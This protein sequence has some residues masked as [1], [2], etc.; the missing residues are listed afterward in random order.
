MEGGRVK[1]DDVYYEL[2]E[3]FDMSFI[4]KYGTV[5][6]VFDDQNSGNICFGV[7][8]GTEKYFVKFAG[9]PTINGVCSQDEAIENLKVALPVYYDLAHENLIHLIKHEE[10]GKGYAAVFEWVDGECMGRMYPYSSRKFMQMSLGEKL[11]VFKDILKFH[12]YVHEK[13]YVAI[14]FY[15][16]SVLYDFNNKKTMICDIDFYSKKP[17][18]NNM[19]RLWGSSRFMSLEEFTLGAEIDEVTNVY[20]MGA[21][22]FALFS[23]Y[24][25]SKDQWPLSEELYDVVCRATSDER[26]LR[27]QSIKELMSEWEKF[28]ELFKKEPKCI[29]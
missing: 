3:P 15:D 18:I 28:V 19:E 4:N 16:G 10:I 2:K 25:R 8:N 11:Q 1:I 29:Y 6:K 22:A 14:D 27:Q 5:F 23:N 21:T 13:N 17:Y 12:A 9:A 24:D 26:N 20:T 7:Q